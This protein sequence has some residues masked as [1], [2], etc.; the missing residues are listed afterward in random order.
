MMFQRERS[1]VDLEPIMLEHFIRV[2]DELDCPARDFDRIGSSAFKVYINFPYTAD[3]YRKLFQD[4]HDID[5]RDRELIVADDTKRTKHHLCILTQAVGIAM[6]LYSQC[7]IG[8]FYP[9]FFRRSVSA[10]ILGGSDPNNEHD[11]GM[12]YYSDLHNESNFEM[13][14]DS[15]FTAVIRLQDL[16]C[17]G[18]V[19]GGPVFALT[20]LN[21]PTKPVMLYSTCEDLVD[22]FGLSNIISTDPVDRFNK[23]IGVQIRGGTI[24]PTRDMY[25]SRHRLFHWGEIPHQFH[26][27]IT[28][29]YT[30]KM[31]IGAPFIN[32]NCKLKESSARHSAKAAGSLSLVYVRKPFW[33]QDEIQASLQGGQYYLHGTGKKSAVAAVGG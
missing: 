23:M 10:I 26:E 2:N 30:E 14:Y 17:A 15:K 24:F 16:M 18:K 4:L 13:E 32:Y 6:L 22:T 7:Y 28:F 20:A 8:G 9:C 3:L 19:L 21:D 27:P 5:L 29:S 1:Q 11:S 31:F 33:F 25:S 12:E